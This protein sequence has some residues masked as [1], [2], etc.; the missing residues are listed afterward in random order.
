MSMLKDFLHAVQESKNLVDRK[1]EDHNRRMVNQ[2]CFHEIF[3][4]FFFVNSPKLLPFFEYLDLDEIDILR[5]Y[6]EIYC[7]PTAKD[8]NV[9]AEKNE[10]N[11]REQVFTITQKLC[12]MTCDKQCRSA[13]PGNISRFTGKNQDTPR[14]E[15][16]RVLSFYLTDP[17]KEHENIDGITKRSLRYFFGTD[18]NI[19]KFYEELID[20]KVFPS[21]LFIKPLNTPAVDTAVAYVKKGL[22]AACREVAAPSFSPTNG[23]VDNA[24][25]YYS[26]LSKQYP[27][28]TQARFAVMRTLADSANCYAAYEV[29]CLLYHGT[30]LR[31]DNGFSFLLFPK[32]E[33][34]KKY[35]LDSGFA[36]AEY[37]ANTIRNDSTTYEQSSI[38]GIQLYRK[39]LTLYHNLLKEEN[40]ANRSTLL[41]GI[42]DCLIEQN[43]NGI[44]Y[45]QLKRLMADAIGQL[46]KFNAQGQLDDLKANCSALFGGEKFNNLSEWEIYRDRLYREAALDGDAEALY[47]LAETKGYISDENLFQKSA[48]LGFAKGAANDILTDYKLYPQKEQENLRSAAMMGDLD[49]IEKV[50]KSYETMMETPSLKQKFHH[51]ANL[52][53]LFIPLL[54]C[55]N[56]SEDNKTVA[57]KARVA[58]L[59]NIYLNG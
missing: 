10:K 5:E 37:L 17:K 46:N 49:S 57:L 16:Q 39:A 23:T 28:G 25:N 36:S 21:E 45:P 42:A 20:K 29:G 55:L 47:R 40:P 27:H 24:L 18:E 56:D 13:F 1:I 2:P 58:S 41:Q 7:V 44:E 8:A 53:N 50:V 59:L 51:T 38:S 9:K 54:Y 43:D 6:E 12:K 3:A 14:K 19:V 26:E 31:C 33:T 11:R 4:I 52:D 22:Q 32:Q 34:A 15:A 35:L 30:T 48:N